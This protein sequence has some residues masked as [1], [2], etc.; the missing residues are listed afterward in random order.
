MDNAKYGKLVDF[1]HMLIKTSYSGKDSLQF[2]GA[3]CGNGFDTLFLSNTAGERGF[4]KAFDIQD[5]AI[6]RTN[7]LLAENKIYDNFQVI[8]D[9]H[10]FAGKYLSEKID[11]AVFNLGYLPF[12]DKTV[13]TSPETTIRAISNLLPFL[14]EEGRIFITTYVSHDVGYEIKEVMD[15][16][17]SLDKN[18]YNVIHVRITNKENNPP[19]LY[20]VEKNA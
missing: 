16:L 14:N 18:S 13:T 12:S 19:E 2:V 5:Q 17:N 3:T 11:V 4:V 20:I 9:S 10:E 15:Y 7:S 8:N 1:V 6:E